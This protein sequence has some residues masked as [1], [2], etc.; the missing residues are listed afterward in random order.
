[1]RAMV[2]GLNSIFQPSGA[3]PESV[4]L[5]AGAVPVFMTVTGIVD[6]RPAVAFADRIPSRPASASFGWPVMSSATFA[7]LGAVGVDVHGYRVMAGLDGARRRDPDLDVFGLAGV[8]RDSGELL[9]PYA[10]VNVVSKF[11]GASAAR[12]KVFFCRRRS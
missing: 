10:S 9:V 1:M 6:L 11:C 4:T 7:G 2:F 8:D 3:L 12:L 5:S